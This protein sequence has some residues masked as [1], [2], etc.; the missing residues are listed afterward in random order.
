MTGPQVTQGVTRSTGRI[1]CSIRVQMSV[2]LQ[3]GQKRAP[4]RVYEK[5]AFRLGTHMS[6]DQQKMLCR[7]KT[8][9]MSGNVEARTVLPRRVQPPPHVI[10][11]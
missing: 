3:D 5:M 8:I 6:V 1:H 9:C 4:L 10:G 2:V 11:A 7:K